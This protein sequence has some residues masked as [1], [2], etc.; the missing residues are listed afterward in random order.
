MFAV[1]LIV[2]TVL[3]VVLMLVVLV[4]TRPEPRAASDGPIT[5]GAAGLLAPAGVAVAT[6][7]VRVDFPLML[8]AL[9]VCV[10]VLLSGLTVDRLEGAL[11]LLAYGA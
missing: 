8:G 1:R 5:M 2:A 4:A 7:V 10:P 3:T 11:F 9:L 6:E